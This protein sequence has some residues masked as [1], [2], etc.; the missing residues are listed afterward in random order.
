MSVSHLEHRFKRYVGHSIV[1]YRKRTRLDQAAN[2]I[3]ETDKSMKD[4]MLSVGFHDPS[5]F[6]KEFRDKY[7]LPPRSIVIYVNNGLANETE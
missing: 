1:Q 6:A 5:R 3:R 4:I 7:A 2:L